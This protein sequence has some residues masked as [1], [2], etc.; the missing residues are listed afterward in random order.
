M[1]IRYSEIFKSIQGEGLRIGHP[2]LWLRYFGC[3]L[4]CAGFGQDKPSDPNSYDLPVN[5]LD[6]S[7][8][9]TF[10]DIPFFDK[11]CDSAYSVS[12]KFKDLVHNETPEIVAQRLIDLWKTV[13]RNQTLDLAF[14]GGEPLLKR[15]QKHTVE[16]LDA[17]SNMSNR[18]WTPCV[19]FETNGTQRLTVEL[20]DALYRNSYSNPIFSVSP[21]LFTV[22]GEPRNKAIKPDAVKS[23]DN[24]NMYFKFVVSDTDECYKELDEVIGIYKQAGIVRPVYLMPVGAT[25][26]S[27]QED[28]VKNIAEYCLEKNYIFCPRLHCDIW[29]NTIGT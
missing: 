25:K 8:I 22:S 11:G 24:F 7:K 21:K 18:T 28:H 10:D 4:N 13:D 20:D 23:Y 29:G 6:F 16:V 27:Q 3:N 17:I 26:E 12:G 14:T 9:K 2:T 1:T 19:T 15:N 5:L